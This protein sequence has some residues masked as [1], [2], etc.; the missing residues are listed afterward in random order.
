MSSDDTRLIRK[1]GFLKCI[2][3][4]ADQLLPALIFPR[5][6]REFLR[7]ECA[8]A[9]SV[10]SEHTRVMID[11]LGW[12]REYFRGAMD[13][14]EAAIDGAYGPQ[15][16]LHRLCM[17]LLHIFP[18]RDEEV[19]VRVMMTVIRRL[20]VPNEQDEKRA[21]KLML[22]DAEQQLRLPIEEVAN[23]CNPAVRALA[24]WTAAELGIIIP[25]NEDSLTG[26]GIVS[27][28]SGMSMMRH[29]GTVVIPRQD[30]HDVDHI[31]G[32]AGDMLGWMCWM[33]VW[34]ATH[35]PDHVAIADSAR[36]FLQRR[37][38][39]QTR[40]TG[41]TASLMAIQLQ[42]NESHIERLEAAL[43]GRRPD[44]LREQGSM[45]IAALCRHAGG[46]SVRGPRGGFLSAPVQELAAEMIESV[47]SE[48]R[49]SRA[50]ATRH[51]LQL[52]LVKQA[53][54]RE[55]WDA[56]LLEE[57][58]E[59]HAE[60]VDSVSIIVDDPKGVDVNSSIRGMIEAEGFPSMDKL[61]PPQWVKSLCEESSRQYEDA[62]SGFAG[63]VKWVP[64]P[65]VPS[66]PKGWATILSG[67]AR[68]VEAELLYRFFDPVLDQFAGLEEEWPTATL[69]VIRDGVAGAPTSI[70][71]LFAR[72]ILSRRTASANDGARSPCLGDMHFLLL[73][74]GHS[75]ES[76][77]GVGLM[78]SIRYSIEAKSSSELQI[79]RNAE[80]LGGI[81]RFRID[82]AHPR[83]ADSANEVTRE[84]ALLG[85]RIMV[86]YLQFLVWCMRSDQAV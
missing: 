51:V 56:E 44:W 8:A 70:G 40:G 68:A 80:I 71:H 45:L 42:W 69:K 66:P 36:M 64:S 46:G 17:E 61:P 78:R 3:D 11:R 37:E 54:L 22:A 74:R 15:Q 18:E 31:P 79:R 60:L 81:N 10:D 39:L 49:C 48:R 83:E 53:L 76:D 41:I 9:S 23:A 86:H 28:N 58:P 20:G 65:R 2:D 57:V 29:D 85:R 32:L 21:R 7:Q 82:S 4:A 16:L 72:M 5:I 33:P 30:F 1:I 13:S 47:M 6:Y 12:S 24:D 75:S 43:K 62:E 67:Y 27:P 55:D 50:Q 84:R 73:M 35:V 14:D 25:W 63:R 34:G 38:H 52:E 77:Q 19:R 59:L 26:L